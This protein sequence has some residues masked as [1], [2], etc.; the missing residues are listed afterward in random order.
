MPHHQNSLKEHVDNH[1]PID[2]KMTTELRDT[3]DQL[4]ADEKT[5]TP[6]PRY[7]TARDTTRPRRRTAILDPQ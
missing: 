3:V 1:R 5:V 4:T 6:T 2:L 7:T